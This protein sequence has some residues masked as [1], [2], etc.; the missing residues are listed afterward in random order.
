M[1]VAGSL[2]ERWLAYVKSGCLTSE[3]E[4]AAIFAVGLARQVRC[5][6]V[7][8]VLWNAELSRRGVENPVNHSTERG[9]RC[10][11]EAIKRLIEQEHPCGGV[12]SQ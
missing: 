10:A 8:N 4:C 11:V 6:A 3:M 12:V 7:L 9:V 1:P 2:V 5:G